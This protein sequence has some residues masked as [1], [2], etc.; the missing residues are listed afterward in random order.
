[1]PP[2]RSTAG[3]GAG[4]L[5]LM[6]AACTVTPVAVT[7]GERQTRVSADLAQLTRPVE[8][9]TA[10]I[11][12]DEALRRAVSH[13]LDQRVKLMETAVAQGQLDVVRWDI[14]RKSVV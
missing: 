3:L 4:V 5:A 8:P 13:N 1:M 11:T 10:P 2:S 6:L 12:L 7:D 14:D 9:V